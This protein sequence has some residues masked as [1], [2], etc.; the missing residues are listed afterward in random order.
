M[1]LIQNLKIT[2]LQKQTYFGPPVVSSIRM[3]RRKH[4]KQQN[5]MEIEDPGW[6]SLYMSNNEKVQYTSRLYQ[7]LMRYS[8]FL[9]LMSW[10]Q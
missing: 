1:V 7:R 6:L 2:D 4:L 3:I 8:I 5:Y 10:N 9:Y